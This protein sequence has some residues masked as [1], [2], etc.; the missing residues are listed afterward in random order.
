M[1]VPWYDKPW[2]IQHYIHIFSMLVFSGSSD[3][4]A[5]IHFYE[6]LETDM[7]FCVDSKYVNFNKNT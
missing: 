6:I 5:H 1:P 4:A 7:V 3:Y 2:Q